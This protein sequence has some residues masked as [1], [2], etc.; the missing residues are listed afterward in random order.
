MAAAPAELISV[1]PAT[2]G[3][4]GSLDYLPSVSGDGNIVAFTAFPANLANIAFVITDRVVIRN[5]AA[6]TTTAVPLPFNVSTTT[7]GVL[8]RDGC[9]VAFWAFFDSL[10]FPPFFVL[11]AQWE[12]FSWDRCTAGSSPFQISTAADFP[13]LTAAGD[14]RGPLAISAD[15]RYVAY[16][17]QPAATL[18]P[19]VAR[20]DTSVLAEALLFHTPGN[21]TSIDISDDGVFVAIGGE[22]IINDVGR[23]VVVGWTPPCLAGL[24]LVCNKELLSVGN[25]G[26][27]LSGSS[28]NP[29]VSADGRYVA[30]SSDTADLVSLPDGVLTSEVYV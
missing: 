30:F 11:P 8:S 12:I 5:R 26:Q 1:N 20:I 21:P 6:G 15:G 16:I 3:P 7:G 24:T 27:V 9:H 14:Q 28:F 22:E 19:R 18:G 29:S 25:S 23:D 13:R 4:L 2:G 17:A 10:F